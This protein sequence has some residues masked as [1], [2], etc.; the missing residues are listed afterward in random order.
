MVTEVLPIVPYRQLVFTI[1]RNLRRPFLFDRSLYGELS[2]IAYSSTRDFLRRE[3]AG[4]FR[5]VDHAVPVL[6]ASPQSFGDLIVH[7][8]TSTQ[9]VPSDSS[10][11][12]ASSSPWRTSTSPDSRRSSASGSSG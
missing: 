10:A 3:A 9:F 5:G 4:T 7:N 11:P 2:R 6:V 12:T 1:P 8:P